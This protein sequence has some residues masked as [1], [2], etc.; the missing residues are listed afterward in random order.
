MSPRSRSASRLL[1][2]LS[3]FTLL[4]VPPAPA[5]LTWSSSSRPK[6][7]A[8]SASA[9]TASTA[10]INGSVNPAGYA[11]SY[12]FQYGTSTS[13]GSS[14]ASRSAGSG[15]SYVPVSAS[16]SN[17]KPSTTYHYRIVA[18]NTNGTVSGSDTAFSTAAAAV[19]PPSAVTGAASGISAQSA[20]LGGTVNPNG[21]ATSYYY[22]YGQTSSYGSLTATQS[23]GSGTSTLPEP[24]GVSGL[25]AST[26]YHYRIVASNSA[27]SSY[28]S[29][30][31]FATPAASSYDQLV[32]GDHPVAYYEM[33]GS[34][35][36][37]DLTGN[38]H[39]G[40]YKGGTP[41]S[42]T[43]PNGE[44]AADFNTSGT[45]SGQYL[46]LPSSSVF[47][48]PTA[49]QLTWEAWIRPDVLQFAHPANSDQYVD[50]MGKC[51]NYSPNCEWEARFYSAQTPQGRPHRIS[52]YVF[53]PTAGLG[54]AADWQPASGTISAD[55]WL[56]V[57]GEYQTV[58]TPSSC[59][60]AYSGTIDIWVNGVK[61][62]F[63]SHTPTG[64]MSQYNIVP[65]AGSSPL[66]IGTMALDSWWQGAIGKVAIYDSLLSQ[67]QI[68][69]HYT[70][71]TG[72]SPSGSCAAMCTIP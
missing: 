7:T 10:T 15:N 42:A 35:Q 40:E 72:L 34:S 20:A 71:M 19:L 68:S 24:I 29:D 17:L 3:A 5:S 36:E 48:I 31:T 51:Q 27:G 67:A 26:T 16:L 38:G 61:Q 13:Y 41:V 46:S 18:K 45:H 52:A 25:H 33:N 50:W 9:I 11:T 47:S 66:D 1:L 14:T 8:A 53:N 65:T 56:H 64:C 39:T 22:K 2:Y 30:Q 63:P 58:S 54:S 37:S 60:S 69:A 12:Y 23:A 4:V 6:I 49:H 44:R 28:G 21:A 43:L 55:K 59:N 57:V 32:L 62:N 70:A